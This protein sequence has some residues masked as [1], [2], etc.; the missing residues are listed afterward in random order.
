LSCKEEYAGRHS[1]RDAKL[2]RRTNV[3]LL[4]AALAYVGATA[5][6]RFPAV[7]PRALAGCA[8]ALTLALFTLAI[9][10]YLRFLHGA[11]ELLRRIQTEA[12]ALGFAA[13]AVFSLLYPLLEDLGAPDLG[14]HATPLVLMLGWGLGS[15]LGERRFSPGDPGDEG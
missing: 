12:L 14:T 6:L 13:G 15:W 4:A 8:V 5:A 1:A 10:S 3:W 9:R 11:D 7:V 2:E